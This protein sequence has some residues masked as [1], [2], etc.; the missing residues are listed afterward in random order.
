MNRALFVL[1]RRAWLP[2]VLTVMVLGGCISRGRES[3]WQ[4]G[5]GS[6]SPATLD[7]L[8]EA[9][10]A[11]AK[12]QDLF[13]QAADVNAAKTAEAEITR[14]NNQISTLEMKA[15]VERH[16]RQEPRTIYYGPLGFV[17]NVTEWTLKKL[18]VMY[19]PL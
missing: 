15:E 19:P 3:S 2:V 5:E 17:L 13:Q 18:Y 10:S 16:G 7:Q 11:K 14:L 12:Y 8:A 4:P 9:R 1:P 6:S